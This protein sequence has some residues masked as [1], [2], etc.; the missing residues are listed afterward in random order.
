MSDKLGNGVLSK[1][2]ETTAAVDT[3]PSKNRTAGYPIWGTAKVLVHTFICSLST[4][5]PTGGR[6][7]IRFLNAV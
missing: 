1:V 2:G 3:A 4:T 6:S 7:S 5:R